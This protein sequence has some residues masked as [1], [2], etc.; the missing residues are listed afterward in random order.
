[1]KE[2]LDYRLIFNW[3]KA[4]DKAKQIMEGLNLKSEKTINDILEYE[5][6]IKLTSKLEGI[7]DEWKK[8]ISEFEECIK[9]INELVGRYL[10][11]IENQN[12][13]QIYD[14]LEL[15][16][17]EDFW[18]LFEKYKVF[19]KIDPFVF[20]DII[21]NSTCSI[22]HILG[23]KCVVQNYSE[24]IKHYFMR[25]WDAAKILLDKNETFLTK[26]N[27]GIYLPELSREEINQIFMNYIDAPYANINIL[28]TIMNICFSNELPISNKVK[29]AAKKRRD[30]LVKEVMEGKNGVKVDYGIC[31]SFRD[32]TE[33][34]EEEKKNNCI[35]YIYDRKWIREN[36][37]NATILNNFIYLLE[38]VDFQ[39][40][41]RVVSKE[42]EATTIEKVFTSRTKK[43][44][45]E[46]GVFHFKMALSYIQMQAY[47]QE[48][49]ENG[50]RLENG[51]E[52]F[53]K[54]YLKEEFGISGFK[55]KMPSETATYLEKCRFLLPEMESILKQFKLYVEENE[56]D[57]EL[58]Q[59]ASGAI[60][61]T[62]IPS[63]VKGKYIY[64]E[65]DVFQRIVYDL[66]SDQCMLHW[67]ERLQGKYQTFFELILNSK[68]RK[69]D[70]EVY[71]WDELDW[72]QKKEI[73]KYDSN[74]YI[75][76]D[77]VEKVCIIA[78]LAKNE[79]I[80]YYHY[81]IHMRDKFAQLKDENLVVDDST[82]F[83]KPE[84]DWLS[85]MLNRSKF[86]NGWDIRNKYAHG[87]QAPSDNEQIHRQYYFYILSILIMYVLKI[88]D[89]LDTYFEKNRY[90]KRG[91]C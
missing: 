12:C 20:E 35:Y 56:I 90:K 18:E 15:I 23:R 10:G 88:N 74:E 77:D 14:E 28:E 54:I 38:Y 24:A 7:S 82:L 11:C 21:M 69:C 31:V 29:L 83:S 34:L 68:V 30:V 48:L 53:F 80:N 1:M 79:V 84:Q 45:L 4:W 27:K 60:D 65:G 67:V 9:Q 17:K 72:L 19:K 81:P 73:I 61:I 71:L 70:Y 55:I 47:Y 76:F 41:L 26:R 3:E 40:R 66:F 32:N 5:H 42:L 37:D 16:Y 63:T 64:G 62:Q 39:M 22:Y 36:L 91:V 46:S 43:D 8:H 33:L 50:I 44:Y 59:I 6:V 49:L 58:L 78:D 86:N 89:D 85:Y 87:T 52:W 13:K 51:I 57:A 2:R 25:H 75:H